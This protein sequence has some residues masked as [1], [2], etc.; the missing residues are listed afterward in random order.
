[1]RAA[2]YALT[3][4]DRW[5]NAVD[6]GVPQRR[7]RVVITGVLA[8]PSAAAP[9]AAAGP[10]PTV[11][12]ALDGLPDIEGHPSLFERDRVGLSPADRERRARTRSTY[13]RRLA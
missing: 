12:D 5:I 11:R 8:G 13:A 1:M 3:G 7:K 4:G 6:F 9:V 2:G 10:A